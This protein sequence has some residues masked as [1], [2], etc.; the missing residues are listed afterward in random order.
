MTRLN[1]P[2]ICAF[3]QQL[4]APLGAKRGITALH[5]S[6]AGAILSGRW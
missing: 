1:A 3:R 2:N 6:A 4:S 5:Q